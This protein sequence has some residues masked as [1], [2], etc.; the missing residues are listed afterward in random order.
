MPVIGLI[1]RTLYLY[2]HHSL[3]RVPKNQLEGH[4]LMRYLDALFLSVSQNG[5]D[6]M[7]H[8]IFR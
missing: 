4:V 7:I 8:A 3:T 1:R 2:Q 5:L 6:N